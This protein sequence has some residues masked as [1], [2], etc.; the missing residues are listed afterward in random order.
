MIASYTFIFNEF[1]FVEAKYPKI[2]SLKN[3][4]LY[5]TIIGK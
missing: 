1:I 4:L 3:Y 2:K 5:V